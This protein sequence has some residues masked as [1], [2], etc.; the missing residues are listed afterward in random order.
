MIGGEEIKNRGTVDIGRKGSKVDGGDVQGVKVGAEDRNK[1]DREGGPKELRNRET[2]GV[3][4]HGRGGR[5]LRK[6]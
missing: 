1:R 3:P 6:E 2:E 5:I 4:R